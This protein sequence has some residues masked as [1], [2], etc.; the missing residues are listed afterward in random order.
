MEEE[1][2]DSIDVLVERVRL[3]E[4]Q[5]KKANQSLRDKEYKL[6]RLYHVQKELL[7]GKKFLEIVETIYIVSTLDYAR[8]GI[9]K[10][11]R[12]KNNMKFRTSSHNTT[13]IQGNK[14]KVLREFRVSD[15]VLVERIIHS[16]LKG[17]LLEGEYEFFMIPF[18][19]LERFIQ[20]IV[21]HDIE[22]NKVANETIDAVFALKQDKLISKKWT[23]GIPW[24]KYSKGNNH[25]TEYNKKY[26]SRLLRDYTKINRC[27]KAVRWSLLKEFMLTNIQL[28]S[29]L[30]D[31]KA[32]VKIV[33]LEQNVTITWKDSKSI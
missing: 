31:L 15:S 29:D 13:H 4:L 10:V 14:I 6:D 3:L 7:N 28:R 18:S 27:Q 11:G 24:H 23:D 26:V 21:D 32:V 22:Q 33:A 8:Q 1:H 17:V 9:F 2:R 30:R 20:K 25:C 19:T 12:S 16:K 5:N